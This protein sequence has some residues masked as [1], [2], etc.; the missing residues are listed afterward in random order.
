MKDDKGEN[1]ERG[2]RQTGTQTDTQAD[3][4]IEY[5]NGQTDRDSC[6]LLTFIK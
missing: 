4:Q 6:T 5:E 3:N 2:H 1:I